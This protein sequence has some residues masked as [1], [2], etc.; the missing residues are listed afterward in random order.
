MKGIRSGPSEQR[1]SGG[2]SHNDDYGRRE[3]GGGGGATWRRIS[4][5]F[6]PFL[7]KNYWEQYCTFLIATLSPPW[8]T[9]D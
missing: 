7:F 3:G 1:H 6:G 9:N 2:H 8:E 4:A 5:K